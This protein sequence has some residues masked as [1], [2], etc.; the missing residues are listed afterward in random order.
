MAKK[1]NLRTRGVVKGKNQ[2]ER[3]ESA[4]NE[5]KS[6]KENSLQILADKYH[7]HIP[8]VSKYISSQIQLGKKQK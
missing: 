7:L 2:Q 1:K 4:Y 3:M 5:W 6:G 8:D